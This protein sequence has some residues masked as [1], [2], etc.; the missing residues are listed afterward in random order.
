MILNSFFEFEFSNVDILKFILVKLVIFLIIFSITFL[1]YFLKIIAGGDGKVI[2]ISF[3]TLHSS[4]LNLLSIFLFFFIFSFYFT[5]Y[6]L[7]RLFWNRRSK[8]FIFFNFIFSEIKR[9]SIFQKISFL[10]SYGLKDLSELKICHNKKR[11]IISNNIIFNFYNKKL[12]I[13]IL[14]RIPL[15]LLIS[16][17]FITFL[18]LLGFK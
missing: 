15:I 16:S 10:S 13:F 6:H 3:L 9:N 8:E 5:L 12:Q 14:D 7:L 4:S 11:K 18:I 2:L 1:F 17:S